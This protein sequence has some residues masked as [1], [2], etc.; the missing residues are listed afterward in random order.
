[1]LRSGDGSALL[2]ESSDLFRCR[3]GYGSDLGE[4][5]ACEEADIVGRAVGELMT[6]Y[7]PKHGRMGQCSYEVGKKVSATKGCWRDGKK[8][9]SLGGF[10]EAV[11]EERKFSIGRLRFG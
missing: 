8:L 1:M 9:M 4:I 5:S 6:L 10:R 11:G 3:R 7:M 2:Y